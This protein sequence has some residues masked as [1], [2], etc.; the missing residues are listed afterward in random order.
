MPQR[1]ECPFRYEFCGENRGIKCPDNVWC[2]KSSMASK[3]VE[4]PQE[5][6]ETKKQ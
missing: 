6:I 2:N 3:L 4:M 5:K 1:K